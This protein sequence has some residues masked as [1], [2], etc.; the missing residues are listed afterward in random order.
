MKFCYLD[1]TG[2]GEEP[3]V[4]LVAI[5]VDVQRMNL[6]KREWKGLFESL[7][8]LATKPVRQ[9]HARDLIPGNGEWRGV[10]ASTRHQVVDT[11]LAWIAKRKH[12]ITFAAV[13]KKKFCSL[14]DD[15]IRKTDLVNEW[16]TSAY[17]IVLS[18]QKLHKNEKGNK[19]DT[20]L[21]FD[22][23][24]PP[25]DLIR[26]IVDPPAWS[27]S[28]YDKKKNKDSLDN[29]IDVPFFAD[30][31][32][33]PLVQVADLI[34]YIL[35]YYCEYIDY[36]KR[37][38]KPDVFAHYERWVQRIQEQCIDTSFR[39]VAKGRACETAIFFR[40]LAPNSLRKLK[41]GKA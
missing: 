13:D 39:Y 8:E 40:E 37:T 32:Y 10:D 4:I 34:C 28:Y 41:T 22:M 25:K 23:H 2:T 36:E 9:I 29:I 31:Q 11:I 26:L 38:H 5:I 7:S 12:K 20:L 33:I 18:L 14:S 17:H 16:N 21:I 6:T 24:R 1:E 3:V 30:S 19:G 27:D 15:S 35:R